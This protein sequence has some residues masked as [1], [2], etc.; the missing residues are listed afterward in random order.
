MSDIPTGADNDD[1]YKS[2]PGQSEIPVQG[3][4]AAVDS[5][6]NP[7]TEDS[8]AQLG[9]QKPNASEINNLTAT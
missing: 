3:D 5:G 1:S 8:D 9:M 6:V 2:R 4:N 7:A